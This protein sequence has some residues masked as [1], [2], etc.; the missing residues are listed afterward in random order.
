ML[1]WNLLDDTTIKL[2]KANIP[3]RRHYFDHVDHIVRNHPKE[4]AMTK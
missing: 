1:N 4:L 3:P 2:I